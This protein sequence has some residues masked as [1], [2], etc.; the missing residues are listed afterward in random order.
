M[1]GKWDTAIESA[2]NQEH[3]TFTRAAITRLLV[4]T[5]SDCPTKENPMLSTQKHTFF[6]IQLT[7][8]VLRS[9][10]KIHLKKKLVFITYRMHVLTTD[11]VPN[12]SQM[13]ERE[14]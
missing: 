10:L 1:Q 7:V 12:Q 13:T 2:R 14:E 6:T 3:K 5:K 4:S 8:S 9:L 11:C